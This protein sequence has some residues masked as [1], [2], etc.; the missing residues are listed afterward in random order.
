MLIKGMDFRHKDVFYSVVGG[1]KNRGNR[2]AYQLLVIDY[3]TD[4]GDLVPAVQPISFFLTG[5]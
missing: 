2:G 4:N 1:Q 5:H 3:S